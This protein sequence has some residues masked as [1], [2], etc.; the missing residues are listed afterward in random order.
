MTR[1][2]LKSKAGRPNVLG[3]GAEYQTVKLRR[4]QIKAINRIAGPAPGRG[5]GVIRDLLDLGIKVARSRVAR[6]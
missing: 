1:K 4:D 3:D 6:C 2:P 5:P